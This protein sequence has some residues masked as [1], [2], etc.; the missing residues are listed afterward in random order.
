[1][2]KH[3]LIVDDE[4]ELCEILKF[5]FENEGYCV[6]TA[7]LADEALRLLKQRSYHLIILDMMLGGMSGLKM[8]ELIRKEWKIET[9]IVF[10]TDRDSECDML[11]GFNVGADD[12]I[13]KPF[14]IKEVVARVKAVMKRTEN[15]VSPSEADTIKIE[16]M[17][18]NSKTKQVYID[19][20]TISLTKTEFE[21]LR[22]FVKN[23]G[24]ILSRENILNEIWQNTFVLE[25]TVDVH[26]TRLRKKLGNYGQWIKN[27][28]G[29]GYCFEAVE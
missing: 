22:Y 29:Y 2:S 5:N 21:I 14:S 12:Y 4:A 1:M 28:Q 19:N 15:I 27:R 18:I 8:V 24:K 10:L 13:S 26:I 17:T 6:D 11:T 20:Q 23:A 16:N 9:P 25:R 3:I 7:G